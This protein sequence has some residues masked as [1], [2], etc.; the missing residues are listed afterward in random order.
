M[1]NNVQRATKTTNLRTFM[2]QSF[3]VNHKYEL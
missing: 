1:L 2:R 3:D